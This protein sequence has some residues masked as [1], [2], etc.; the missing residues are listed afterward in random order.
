METTPSSQSIVIKIIIT[1]I[2]VLVELIIN[3]FVEVSFTTSLQ[4]LFYVNYWFIVHVY[5]CKPIQIVLTSFIFIMI[6][7]LLWE[8]F[9]LRY[10]LI[11][12]L[13]REFKYTFLVVLVFI[14][15]DL[16]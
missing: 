7:I 9:P 6:L 5:L 16:V 12:T 15:N 8:T 2:L 10:G 4:S 11:G 14:G 1:F 13:F 3:T